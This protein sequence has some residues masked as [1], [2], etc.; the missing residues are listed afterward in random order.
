MLYRKIQKDNLTE[1]ALGKT[2]VLYVIRNVINENVN[3]PVDY[4]TKR[5]D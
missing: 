2:P 5:L 1:C 4:V 3:L